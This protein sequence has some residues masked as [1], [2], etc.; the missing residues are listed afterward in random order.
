MSS[1]WREIFIAFNWF[2]N[3]P[4][5]EN[6]EK[7]RGNIRLER[8]KQKVEE[9]K[10]RGALLVTRNGNRGTEISLEPCT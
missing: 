4:A 5:K 3:E 8:E 1:P 6:R 2:S 9:G 10:R 7:V